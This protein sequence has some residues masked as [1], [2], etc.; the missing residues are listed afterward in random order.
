METAGRRCRRVSLSSGSRVCDCLL[1]RRVRAGRIV[2]CDYAS[3]L[4]YFPRGVAR[5]APELQHVTKHVVGELEH[6]G[7]DRVGGVF[8]ATAEHQTPQP[9]HVF[10][11]LPS[12]ISPGRRRRSG[13]G[14]TSTW[15][16]GPRR[17]PSQTRG[18]AGACV[19]AG[20]GRMCWSNTR[21]SARRASRRI[22]ESSP[23]SSRTPATRRRRYPLP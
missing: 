2:S 12:I 16:R 21:R 13:A 4:D 19:A 1:A 5:R 20:R 11:G 15:P 17:R 18:A 22:E 7:D 8:C 14:A 6:A 3:F 10:A 23:G 9:Q